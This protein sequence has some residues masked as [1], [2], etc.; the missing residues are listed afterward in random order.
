MF[1]ADH[2]WEIIIVTCA[3]PIAFIGLLGISLLFLNTAGRDKVER[4][5]SKSRSTSISW[6]L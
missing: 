1:W 2:G 3:W 6:R 4:L 5:L